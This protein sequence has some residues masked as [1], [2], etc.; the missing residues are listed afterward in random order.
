MLA[1]VC[2]YTYYVLGAY[3]AEQGGNHH[4]VLWGALS[5]GISLVV[6]YFFKAGWGVLLMAQ[7]GLFIGITVFRAMRESP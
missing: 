1:V 5:L 7:V 6:A 2:A 4:G 3:E